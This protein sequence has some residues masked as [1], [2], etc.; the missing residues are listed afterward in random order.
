MSRLGRATRWPATP[1]SAASWALAAHDQRDVGAGAAHVEGDQVPLAE[2]AR[3]VAA[4]RHTAGRAR[5]H[6]ARRDAHRLADRHH[7]PVGL[8]DQHRARVA[9]GA[10]ALAQARQVARQGWAHVG[11]DHGG[12][13]ALVLLDLREHRR[14]EGH[15]HLRQGA[16][17][18]LR[19]R[20]LVPGV[21]IG[22]EVADR[23]RLDLLAAEGGDG[24]VERA[25]V[26]S[27]GGGA[28]G[29]H[30]LAHAQPSGPRRQGDRRRHAEVVAVVLQALAHLDHVAVALGG[31]K[32]HAGALALEERVGRDGGAVHDAL[33]LGE[34]PGR[35]GAE[36]LGQGLDAVHHPDR[37]IGGRRGG[38]RERDP[39]RVIHRDG[40]GEGPSHVDADPVHAGLP[41]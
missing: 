6:G 1:R 26:E 10:Q 7:A 13:H 9:G 33:G 5:Q 23:D 3:A 38:F 35:V 8:H 2:Q 12:R 15:V 11:V 41:L 30:P 22:V 39:A 29:A 25:G 17:Q 36:G 31:E 40:V 24:A 20:L 37:R 4:A 34:E 27:H 21:A 32:A 16:R 28:V 18:R 14:G 19:R